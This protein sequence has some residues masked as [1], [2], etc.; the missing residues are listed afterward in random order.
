LKG[1]YFW[2]RSVVIL[3]FET[4]KGFSEEKGITKVEGKP[5]L[6]RVVEAVEG[7]TDE[8]IIVTETQEQINL[9]QKLALPDVEFMV[10]S[11]ASKG[12][13]AMACVA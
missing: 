7:C 1:V 4:P 11:D 9:Y 13:L 12:P 5:L 2:I 3:A 8:T 6:R 10:C